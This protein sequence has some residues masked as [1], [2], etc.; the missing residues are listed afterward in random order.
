MDIKRIVVHLQRYEDIYEP[1]RIPPVISHQICIEFSSYNDHHL[2]KLLKVVE[3][4]HDTIFV[5]QNA[6]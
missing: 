2:K 5:Q 1:K 4:T 3:R 6:F